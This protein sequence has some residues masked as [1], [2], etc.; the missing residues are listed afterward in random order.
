MRTSHH[1]AAQRS[2]YLALAAVLLSI[3]AVVGTSAASASDAADQAAPSVRGPSLLGRAVLPFDTFAEGPPAGAF[4][5]PGTGEPGSG[6]V[7][8]VAFPLPAQP[9][10]GFSAIVD[11][12][13]SRRVP[14]DARQ[15]LRLQG[16]LA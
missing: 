4:V 11:G 6:V 16:E 13:A 1:G 8:G 12:R 2:S 9:V 15:R 10:E 5:V 14:G 3:P 7:N